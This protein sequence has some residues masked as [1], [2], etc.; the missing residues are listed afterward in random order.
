MSIDITK[1]LTL[2]VFDYR[3][4]QSILSES[5]LNKFNNETS[6]S[7]LIELEETEKIP[8]TSTRLTNPVKPTSTSSPEAFQNCMN[9]CR[10]SVSPPNIP[11]ALCCPSGQFPPPRELLDPGPIPKQIGNSCEC[12]K[13]QGYFDFCKDAAIN[14]CVN[15]PACTPEILNGYI[16]S[17]YNKS[18]EHWAEEVRKAFCCDEVVSKFAKCAQRCNNLSRGRARRQYP[19]YD[20]PWFDPKEN[21]QYE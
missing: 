3:I 14:A 21:P 7:S 1:L 9:G 19:G 13:Q 17:C 2:G 11:N 18:L 12:G 8:T 6:E 5:I 15:N 16:E 4:V 10:K 20:D